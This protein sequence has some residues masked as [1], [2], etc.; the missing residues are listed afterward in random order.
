M[1]GVLAK[2]IDALIVNCSAFNPTPS[3]SATVVNHFKLKSS[4]KTF[5]LSGMGCAASV[6]AVDLA[7]ELMHNHANMT[8]LIA[9]TENILNNLYFGNQ[10]SM[11]I[12]NCI[13]RLGGM[14]ALMSNRPALRGKAKY[15]LCHSVRTHL[16]AS[17]EAYKWVPGS[18]SS[19]CC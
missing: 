3:L 13:F 14:S 1:P 7:K 2:D 12:T 8:V 16:G 19:G 9:G 5:N 17:D 18:W 6:I 11:L 4:V 15:R 10:R